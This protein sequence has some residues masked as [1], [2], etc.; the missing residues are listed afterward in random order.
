MAYILWAGGSVCCSDLPLIRPLQYLNA[1]LVSSPD[2]D[3]FVVYVC[4]SLCSE[5]LKFC[6]RMKRPS[7]GY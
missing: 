5:C 7:S 6:E 3:V 1:L 4:M 2:C